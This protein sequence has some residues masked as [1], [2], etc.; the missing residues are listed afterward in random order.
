MAD[1]YFINDRPELPFIIIGM[2][3]S[4]GFGIASPLFAAVFGDMLEVSLKIDQ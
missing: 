2:I 1:I 4:I 3:A